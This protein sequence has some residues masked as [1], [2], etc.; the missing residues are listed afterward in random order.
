MQEF[1]PVRFFDVCA[2]L[3]W[4]AFESQPMY[5]SGLLQPY[6]QHY[7]L[8][9]II[10]SRL[11]WHC[12]LS[13]H[14]WRL[15]VEWHII[16]EILTKALALQMSTALPSGLCRLPW[17]TLFPFHVWLEHPAWSR[18]GPCT[19]WATCTPPDWGMRRRAV[20]WKGPSAVLPCFCCYSAWISDSCVQ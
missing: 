20:Q 7:F 5:C 14:T 13:R 18:S 16:L 6:L 2:E 19:W 1:L 10:D 15:G 9:K 11:T 12:G 17:S 8:L 3:C 4:D